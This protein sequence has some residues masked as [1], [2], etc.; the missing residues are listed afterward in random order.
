MYIRDE[1]LESRVSTSAPHQLHLMVVEGAIRYA[2]QAR[3]S[4]EQKDIETAHLALNRSREFVSELIS[5]VKPEQNQELAER[6][7]GLFVFAYRN[8][9]VADMEQEPRA[10]TDALR[11]LE[12]HRDTWRMLCDQLKDEPREGAPPM[13]FDSNTDHDYGE[14]GFSV[15]S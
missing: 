12:M 4:L 5:G 14:G 6:V 1:Y 3:E 13:S 2:K 9:A 8:L 15:L 10:V 11:V 7:Q